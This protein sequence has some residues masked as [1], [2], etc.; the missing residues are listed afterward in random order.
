[1]PPIP[2]DLPTWKAQVTE[3]GVGNKTLNEIKRTSGSKIPHSAFLQLRAIWLPDK[4]ASEAT[5]TLQKTGLIG[6][7]TELIKKVVTRESPEED[8]FH[9]FLV[10][11]GGS[12]QKTPAPQSDESLINAPAVESQYSSFIGPLGLWRELKPAAPDRVVPSTPPRNDIQGQSFPSLDFEKADLPRSISR[13]LDSDVDNVT[14]FVMLLQMETPSKVRINES[15]AT[16]PEELQPGDASASPTCSPPESPA[17]ASGGEAEA[18]AGAQVKLRTR[19]E[20]QTSN[21]FSS[22]FYAFFPHYLTLVWSRYL[23]VVTEEASYRFGGTH[24]VGSCTAPSPPIFVARTD[25][26]FYEVGE[27]DYRKKRCFLPFELKPYCRREKLDA[28]CR[29]ETAEMAAV[30]YEEFVR[31]KQR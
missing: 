3:H 15:S 10:D 8:T 21:F 26:A 19:Y 7:F 30:I 29:E 23:K 22:F 18:E 1:M 20:V 4:I 9:N 25:G 17:S 5:E 13:D 31:D 24:P 6:D 11:I 16:P 14:S 27:D 12:S 2:R 28:T